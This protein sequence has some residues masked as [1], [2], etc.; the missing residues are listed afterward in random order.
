MACGA[1]RRCD[2]RTPFLPSSLPVLVVALA[3]SSSAAIARD[4]SNHELL[5]KKHGRVVDAASGAG[6]PN[7]KVIAVWNSATTGTYADSSGCI[8]QKI[9]TTNANGDFVIPDVSEEIEI[10]HNWQAFWFDLFGHGAP[11]IRYN[12]QLTVYLPGYVRAGDKETVENTPDEANL[13][14]FAWR[15]RPPDVVKSYWG[16]VQIKPIVMQKTELKPPDVW[17]YYSELLSNA[18]CSKNALTPKSMANNQREMTEIARSVSALVRPLP[19]AMPSG[20]RINSN[21]LKAFTGVVRDKPFMDRMTALEGTWMWSD[22]DT[23]A[24]TLCRAL[25]EEAQPQ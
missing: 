21:T 8:D 2:V 14:D 12:W 22:K 1:F 18:E 15:Q 3:I 20:T 19:C 11:E 23:T 10:Q 4:I 24:G 25:S 5:A 13:V 6:V 9:A 17:R 7:V 16:D